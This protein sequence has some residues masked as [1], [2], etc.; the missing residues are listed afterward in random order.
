MADDDDPLA[1]ACHGGPDVL[2][3]RT[4]CKALV[5]QRIRSG[6]PGQLLPGLARTQ[7]GAG[8]DRIGFHA[9]GCETLAEGTRFR[10]AFARQ[11][12]ELVRLPGYCIGVSDEVE[13]HRPRI[14]RPP[15]RGCRAARDRR[16]R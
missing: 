14:T 7:E 10:S 8:Q 15:A 5:W 6:R 3:G 2:G 16:S 12:A 11:R 13:L 9:F 1:A 4:G